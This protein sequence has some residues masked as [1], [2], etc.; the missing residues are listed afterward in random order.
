MNER[1]LQTCVVLLLLVWHSMTAAQQPLPGYRLQE[2][3]E[4]IFLHGPSD[5]LAPPVDGNSVIVVGDDE[6][7]VVDTH[8]N[9]AAARAAIAQLRSLSNRPVTRIINTHW[10]DDHVNGN[11]TY[12]QAF[13]AVPII[14]HQGTLAALR[15]EWPAMLEQRRN[16]Y[17]TAD[18]AAILAAA[19][20]LEDAEKA[21]S[22]RTYAGYV[23][24]LKPEVLA[25]QPVY[26]DTVFAERIEFRTGSRSLVVQWLG[27]GNTD[28]DAVVWLPDDGVLI[29]GDLLVAPIPFAFD[30]PMVQWADTLKRLTEFGAET[31]IPGHGPAQ[32]DTR[33][34][35]QVVALLEAT[36]DAVREAHTDGVA[37]AELSAHIDLSEFEAR[38]TG[39]DPE[40][41][42]AWNA[43]YV[44]PGLKSAWA[45]LGFALPEQ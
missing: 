44:T 11:Q 22:Y 38:F 37:Y 25:L 20:A 17:A 8:I 27:R 21:W 34:L 41:K 15:R 42:H 1:A 12:R 18:P 39:G 16:G 5:P 23:Q 10:H 19:D 7:T 36:L 24:A 29:T 31:I 14:A 9:P 28:G 3:T 40:L 2:V 32:S 35:E 4:G 26:P 45:S 6:V 30:A 43:F 33:Y 13:S